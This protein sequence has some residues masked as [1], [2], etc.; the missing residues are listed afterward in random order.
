MGLGLGLGEDLLSAV[1]GGEGES[2][3]GGREREEVL[4]LGV[5]VEGV[6]VVAGGRGVEVDVGVDEVLELVVLLVWV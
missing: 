3:K 5:G 4:E 1:L 2:E 6:G